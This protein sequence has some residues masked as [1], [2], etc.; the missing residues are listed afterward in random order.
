MEWSPFGKPPKL[1][2]RT[3]KVVRPF[4][5]GGGKDVFPP[6][7]LNIPADLSAEEAWIKV[8]QGFVRVPREAASPAG[9]PPIE[10][11]DPTPADADPQALRPRRRG[12]GSKRQLLT[13][14]Q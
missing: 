6:A 9:R 1:A 3:V 10:Q 12:A 5:L 11:G 2:A 7:I 8:R 13:E 4:C 14:E